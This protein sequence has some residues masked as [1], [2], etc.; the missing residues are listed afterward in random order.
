MK[1]NK[2]EE[3]TKIIKE[4]YYTGI[5]QGFHESDALDVFISD[6]ID[7]FQEQLTNRDKKMR[8]E[9][10]KLR[11]KVDWD[12]GSDIKDYLGGYNKA[13]DDVLNILDGGRE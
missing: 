13:L 8:E 12:M 10:E 4:I 7:R 2:R 3:I 9:A 1:P 5:D 11:K 6:W